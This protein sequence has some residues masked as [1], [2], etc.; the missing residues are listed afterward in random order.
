LVKAHAIQGRFLTFQERTFQIE[1]CD[2]LDL[3]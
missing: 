2:R 1:E 3:V